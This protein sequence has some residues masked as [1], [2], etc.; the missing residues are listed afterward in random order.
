MASL[1][2]QISNN[3]QQ[4][5]FYLQS[6]QQSSTPTEKNVSAIKPDVKKAKDSYYNSKTILGSLTG[7][8]ILG[9]CIWRL[10]SGKAPENIKKPSL[11][12]VVKPSAEKIQA[13]IDALTPKITNLKNLIKADYIAKRQHIVDKLN[14]FDEYSY[15]IPFSNRKELTTT[16]DNLEKDYNDTLPKSNKIIEDNRAAIRKTLSELSQNPE[17][18]EL[19][20]ARKNLLKILGNEN[21]TDDEIMIARDKISFIN[22][23]LVNRAHPDLMKSYK[24]IS[25]IDDAQALELVRK[26][27]KVYNRFIQK[28]DS[29]KDKDV[30]LRFDKADKYFDHTGKLSL[31]DIF[32]DE[33][34]SIKVR[35]KSL[36]TKLSKLNAAKDILDKLDKENEQLVKD[37]RN[38][39]SV[40]Q[41]K[42]LVEEVKALKKS[43]EDAA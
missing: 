18:K 7:L 43:L 41:L 39:E 42:S 5:N 40:K 35:S 38:T 23:L 29:M 34:Q 14:T 27:F 21:K 20:L 25:A 6:T 4:Q 30:K 19:K 12:Q 1:F 3:S 2:Q 15:K 32:R 8:G 36:K 31:S 22:D 13:D 37:Y 33:M 10:K 11:P 26:N 28:L 24:E 17:W 16:I 9:V